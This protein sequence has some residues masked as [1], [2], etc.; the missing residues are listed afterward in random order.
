MLPTASGGAAKVER[1]FRTHLNTWESFKHV[2]HATG[3]SRSEYVD[4]LIRREVEEF[5]R[6]QTS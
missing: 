1:S 4:A 5:E 3:R 2:A 6:T